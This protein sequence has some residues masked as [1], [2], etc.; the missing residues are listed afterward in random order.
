MPVF[1]DRTY[2]CVVWEEEARMAARPGLDAV[3]VRGPA[4]TDEAIDAQLAPPDSGVVWIPGGTYRMGSDNHYPEEA[5]AHRVT[6]EGFWIDHTPVTNSQFHK[7]V[8]ATGY[9]TFA[10]VAPEAKDYPGAVDTS[11][12]HAGFRCVIRKQ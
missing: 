6:V 4:E 8:A 3:A 2:A 12:S 7:F 9:V 5:P 11:T 1:A 10:E